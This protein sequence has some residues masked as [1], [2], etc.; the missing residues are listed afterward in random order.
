[1]LLLFSVLLL[2]KFEWFYVEWNGPNDV[3]LYSESMSSKF[4]RAV[5]NK[6]GLQR[7][8]YIS[9]NTFVLQEN[10]EQHVYL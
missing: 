10:E 4:A 2:L 6:L 5:G 9:Y 8:K 3:Y 7:G 1:M